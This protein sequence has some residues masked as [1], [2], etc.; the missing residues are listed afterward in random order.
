MT[1]ELI[2]VLMC[3]AQ[4]VNSDYDVS[5]DNIQSELDLIECQQRELEAKGRLLE[6][7]IRSGKLIKNW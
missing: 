1:I 3:V 4:E 5:P 6:Q 7:A 2:M